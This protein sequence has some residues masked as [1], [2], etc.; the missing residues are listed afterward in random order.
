MT[1]RFYR[2][3]EVDY[4]AELDLLDEEIGIWVAYVLQILRLHS[5]KTVE[6]ATSEDDSSSIRIQ[7][8]AINMVGKGYVPRT[9]VWFEC[10]N[11]DSDNEKYA[12]PQ[13]WQMCVDPQFTTFMRQFKEDWPRRLE[14]SKLGM[15]NRAK[16]AAKEQSGAFLD[17]IGQLFRR[18]FR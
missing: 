8:I 14:W 4:D 15:A 6:L 2:Y 12:E 1:A 5:N 10:I 13:M 9:L 17:P 11:R 7:R 18:W 3:P 16:V